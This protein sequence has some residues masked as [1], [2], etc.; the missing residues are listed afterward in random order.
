M[1]SLKQ[2]VRESRGASQTIFF[3]HYPTSTIGSSVS[4]IRKL[5]GSVYRMYIDGEN[6]TV[7]SC[8]LTI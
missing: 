7:M 1:K 2:F 6:S 4:D 3:G 8:I 5:F